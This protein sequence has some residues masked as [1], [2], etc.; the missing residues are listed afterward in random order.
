MPN[1][2]TTIFFRSDG[3]LGYFSVSFSSSVRALGGSLLMAIAGEEV[4]QDIF[5][6]EDLQFY[7]SRKVKGGRCTKDSRQSESREVKRQK[8][9]EQRLRKK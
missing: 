7:G 2:T 9:N 1:P 5:R 3:T 4:A 8:T 6:W